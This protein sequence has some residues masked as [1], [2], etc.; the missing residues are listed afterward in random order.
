MVNLSA[1][2]GCMNKKSES[3]IAL[4]KRA[5]KV[6]LTQQI[7]PELIGLSCLGCCLGGWSLF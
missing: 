7:R 5:R 3:D 2:I 6:R 4:F 1:I